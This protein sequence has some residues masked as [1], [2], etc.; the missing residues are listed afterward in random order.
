MASKT[1][2]AVARLVIFL[3]TLFH[4]R[5]NRQSFELQTLELVCLIEGSAGKWPRPDISTK[6]AYCAYWTG[7]VSY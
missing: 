5:P 2:A 6:K 3:D 7:V 4:S 1:S